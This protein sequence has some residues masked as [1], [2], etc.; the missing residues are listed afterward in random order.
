[1]I[2]NNLSFIFGI[3]SI[4]Y[5]LI[6]I[7]LVPL[8]GPNLF[9]GLRYGYTMADKRVWVKSNRFLGYLATIQGLV[10]IAMSFYVRETFLVGMAFIFSN[11]IIALASLVRAIEYANMILGY[12]PREEGEI[13][14]IRPLEHSNLT[15]F[16][17]V[18]SFLGNLMIIVT[19]YNSFNGYIA[20]HFDLSGR[21]DAFQSVSTF[22][23]LSLFFASTIFILFLA[24]GLIGL[25]YPMFLHS[26]VLT[27]KWGREALFRL[28]SYSFIAAESIFLLVFY[29]IY[30]YNVNG[31]HILSLPILIAIILTLALTPFIIVILSRGKHG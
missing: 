30:F 24:I 15:K 16:L 29:D 6:H 20:V 23:I 22:T 4:A 9:I 21:P 8:I 3:V 14:P 13:K 2:L 5:G 31:T 19:I 1:M 18:L 28:I 25:K 27:L 7:L 12:L 10:F 11:V 26:G 17:M